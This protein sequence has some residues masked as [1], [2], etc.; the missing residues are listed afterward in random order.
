MSSCR[1]CPS[2]FNRFPERVAK[3]E[4]VATRKVWVVSGWCTGMTGTEV[5]LVMAAKRFSVIIRGD[6]TDKSSLMITVRVVTWC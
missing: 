4:S 5:L 6:G 1:Q 3:A 2:R